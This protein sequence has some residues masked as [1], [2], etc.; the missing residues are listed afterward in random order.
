MKSEPKDVAVAPSAPSALKALACGRTVRSGDGRLDARAGT[1]RVELLLSGRRR[2]LGDQDDRSARQPTSS[3]EH[4]DIKV[5]PVYAGTYQESIVK[6]MTARQERPAAASRG[7]ALDRH[8]LADRRGRDR[9]SRSASLG[10]AEDKKW[11][12]RVLQGVHDEQH[13]RTARS[14]AC[15]SSA[16][17]SCSTGTRTCSRRPASIRT[18]RRTNWAAMVDVRPEAHAEPM[19]A[20]MSRSGA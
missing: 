14:G 9:P 17:R 19:P 1:G 3:K 4:P 7:A 8:V 11:L 10:S 13:A 12:D 18:R 2:R 5:K 16:R 15:R 20:A 6:A